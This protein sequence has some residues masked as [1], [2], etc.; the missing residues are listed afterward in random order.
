M[1]WRKIHKQIH[2]P[3][4]TVL[5]STHTKAHHYRRTKGNLILHRTDRYIRNVSFTVLRTEEGTLMVPETV[6]RPTFGWT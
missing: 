4:L 1:N 6:L 5:L 2:L 3:V